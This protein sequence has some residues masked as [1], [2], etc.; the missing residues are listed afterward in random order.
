MKTS[1][2]PT[3]ALVLAAPTLVIA[4]APTFQGGGDFDPPNVFVTGTRALASE[5]NAN[6]DAIAAHLAD[7]DGRLDEIAPANVIHV[8]SAG[9]QF[10]SI[11]TAL[12]SITD[13]SDTNRYLVRVGPGVYD[14][15]ELSTV[16]SFV[17]L[18]GSGAS[19]TVLR[20]ARSGASAGGAAAAV[21]LSDGASLADITIENTGAADVSIGVLSDMVGDTTQMTNVRVFVQ[22]AG[23]SEHIAVFASDSDLRVDGCRLETSGALTSNLGY[24]ALG[25]T[26]T[27][28]KPLIVD[29]ILMAEG[30]T[31]GIAI[32]LSDTAATIRGSRIEGGLH[33]I[34]ALVDG[35]SKVQDCTVRV[36]NLNPVYDQG[37]S[38]VLLSA[39][40]NFVGGNATGNGGLL[41]YVHCY[42]SVFDPVTNGT[43]S[44][45]Q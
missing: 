43:G 33:G 36:S 44:D 16:P 28:S 14:E 21:Q 3:V 26:G 38:A 29:S 42:N 45:V 15:S 18:Q 5:V 34:Q 10:T 39:A 7:F 2:L 32:R 41:K 30:D 4:L 19:V 13:A 12:A 24:S 25:T 23:G 1:L 8:S 35:N 31:N 40:V 22:G 37:G 6:F 11:A 9:G 17:A 27:P 20:A